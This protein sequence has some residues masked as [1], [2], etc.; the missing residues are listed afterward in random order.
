MDARH[1]PK[2]LLVLPINPVSEK[3]LSSKFSLPAWARKG[4]RKIGWHRARHCGLRRHR[5]F[6]GQL[7]RGP[8]WDELR[9]VDRDLSSHPPPPAGAFS[10]KNDAARHSKGCGC[11]GKL[12]QLISEIEIE[13]FVSDLT[14]RNIAE[15]PA[16]FVTLSSTAPTT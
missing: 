11:E 12:R 1:A 14:P 9:I 5:C 8:E 6:C 4:Q 16:G 2:R 3:I 10:T 13:G 7:L 15:T